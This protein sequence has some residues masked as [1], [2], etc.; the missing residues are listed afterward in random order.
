M[1]PFVVPYGT[2]I[3]SIFRIDTYRVLSQTKDS[4]L[5]R[6][7]PEPTNC[8]N[9]APTGLID[10][11]EYGTGSAANIVEEYKAKSIVISFSL[12]LSTTLSMFWSVRT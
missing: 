10:L 7:Y 6:I 1:Q 11:I 9:S 3:K 12:I 4:P 2:D 8:I 5:L